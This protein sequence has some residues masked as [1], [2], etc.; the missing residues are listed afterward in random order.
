MWLRR[1]FYHW[2]MPAA[3]ILP[4]WLVIGWGVFQAGGW[5]FLWL[6]FIAIPS[7]FLG[8]LVLTLL[9]RARGTVRAARAV[10]W[11]DLCGFT[12][13]H[14]LIVAV[15]FYNPNWFW[16][17]LGL[18]VAAGLSMFWVSLYQLW[19]EAR[20]TSFVRVETTTAG[21]SYVRPPDPQ[22][23]GDRREPSVIVVNEQSPTVDR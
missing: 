23:P 11:W 5:A 9:V 8:Q 21:I 10:S 17:A 15:G 1:A 13:W 3:L 2:L 20:P 6:L 22:A 19:R 12:V 4:L 18:A 7:V 16:P 14:G